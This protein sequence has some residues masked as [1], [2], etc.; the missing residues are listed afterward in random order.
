[1]AAVTVYAVFGLLY[2]ACSTQLQV[3]AAAQ[4]GV[5]CPFAAAVNIIL[6]MHAIGWVWQGMPAAVQCT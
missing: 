3:E 2:K 1:M 6:C 4:Q 5:C